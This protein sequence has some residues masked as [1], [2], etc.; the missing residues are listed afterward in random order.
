MLRVMRSTAPVPPLDPGRPWW[1]SLVRSPL[2]VLLVAL[3]L[4]G[5]LLALVWLVYRRLAHRK[6][7]AADN[8]SR[9]TPQTPPAPVLTSPAPQHGPPAGDACGATAE[10][11]H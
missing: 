8:G 5:G 9:G 3:L 7:H 1:S 10:R 4:P 2:A 6:T 11:K